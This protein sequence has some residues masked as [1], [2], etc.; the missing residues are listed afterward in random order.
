MLSFRAKSIG[1]ACQGVQDLKACYTLATACLKALQI[2][3]QV[4]DGY[5]GC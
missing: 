3:R 4:S 1:L 2:M 5:L